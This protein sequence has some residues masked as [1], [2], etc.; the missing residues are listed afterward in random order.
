MLS[1]KLTVPVSMICPAKARCG[2]VSCV[3][4]ASIAFENGPLTKVLWSDHGR[5]WAKNSFERLRGISR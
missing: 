2:P 5:T 3:A 4:V 1:R